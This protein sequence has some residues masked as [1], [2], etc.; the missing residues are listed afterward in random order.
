[1]PKVTAKGRKLFEAIAVMAPDNSIVN[2][3]YALRACSLIARYSR[4]I[5]VFSL[6]AAHGDTDAAVRANLCRHRASRALTLLNDT[7][8]Y[9]VGA[10]YSDSHRGPAIQLWLDDGRTLGVP[11]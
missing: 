6:A 11:R 10:Q 2:A 5:T 1:M 7:W 3:I 8:P 4:M 9:V